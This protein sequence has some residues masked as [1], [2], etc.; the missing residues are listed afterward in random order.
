MDPLTQCSPTIN[1]YIGHCNTKNCPIK[2]YLVIKGCDKCLFI[3]LLIIAIWNE[4]MTTS[5]KVAPLDGQGSEV[6]S[7]AYRRN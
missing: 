6:F 1:L 3:S 4:S 7:K 5:L 2:K